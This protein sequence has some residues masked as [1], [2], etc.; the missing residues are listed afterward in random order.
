M[1]RN[2]IV[3]WILIATILLGGYYFFYGRKRSVMTKHALAAEI[4]QHGAGGAYVSGTHE[5]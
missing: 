4:A 5:T 3:R 2:T 1:D